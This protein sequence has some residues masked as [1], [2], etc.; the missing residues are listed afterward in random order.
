MTFLCPIAGRA[1]LWC[2]GYFPGWEQYSSMPASNIDFTALTH[3]IHFSLV[4]KTDGTLDSDA[5]AIA[6]SYSTDLVARAHSA[7]LKVLICVG[8]GGTET[9]FQKSTTT[10]HLP[11]FIN[12]LTNFMATRGYDGIDVDWEPLPTG[13]AVKYTNLIYGLHLA[14]DK[15]PQ[16]KLLTVAAGA[17][18]PYGDP[19]S[20]QYL[21]FAAI[22]DQLDQINIMTYDLSGPYD[23]WVTWFNS[24]LYDGGYRFASSG[25]FVPSVNGSVAN[26]TNNGVAP[27]KL[28]VGVAF[29]G[30]VWT[31][32]TGLSGA[33]LTGP[34]QSWNTAPV[35][36]TPGYTAI[37]S[38]YYQPALYHWDTNAQAAY[39]SITNAKATNNIFLSYDDERTCQAK[40]S[41]A[42]N[43][44]L[45][46]IMIWEL[47]L[48]HTNSA[49]DPLLQAIKQAVAAPGPAGIQCAGD[50][51]DL[52][53]LGIS[54]G[55]YRILWGNALASNSWNTLLITNVPGLGGLLQI[56]DPGVI[57]N[58]TGRFYRVQ[59]PP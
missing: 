12:N 3:I 35:V 58:Q 56:C 28:G 15:F 41:Y 1:D 5:N 50:D 48:D 52:T 7:G 17:Y 59:T 38:N 30:Y 23:G 49:P 22:Q 43:H 25:G 31:G 24:P 8:G 13:D 6:F 53:F 57:T 37:I 27:G 14:L 2:T 19:A 32:G 36:T 40:V 44:N 29:Y 26:F 34:R 54:L 55:S 39:L 46:G 4:P 21:M 47:A 10:A 18:P 33:N 51:I 45:G 16:P 9:V 20:D 11:V 42:R